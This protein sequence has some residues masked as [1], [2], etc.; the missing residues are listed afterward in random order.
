MLQKNLN[1]NSSEKIK[2]QV[3][4]IQKTN[5]LDNYEI[6]LANLNESVIKKELDNISSL[7]KKNNQILISGFM[8]K[9][10][11]IIYQIVEKSN[12]IITEKQELEN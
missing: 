10:E 9:D 2:L 12:L 11:N 5:L 6:I 1:L 7:L 3:G 8:K 4:T